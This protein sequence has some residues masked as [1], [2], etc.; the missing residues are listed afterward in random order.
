MQ[1]VSKKA[2]RAALISGA[3]FLAG[4]QSHVYE[5]STAEGEYSI[6]VSVP[7]GAPTPT[8]ATD[9]LS[10]EASHV[11]PD[12]Y[13]EE[14]ETTASSQGEMARWRVHCGDSFEGVSEGGS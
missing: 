10:K 3:F 4:C 7:R 11:C 5:T 8:A 1:S 6:A 14:N 13:Q 12:G 9:V 2:V